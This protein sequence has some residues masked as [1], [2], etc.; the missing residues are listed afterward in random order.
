MYMKIQEHIVRMLNEVSW[1]DIV[2][3]YPEL[4]STTTLS[5]F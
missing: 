4:S 1:D 3:D 2:R 5:D